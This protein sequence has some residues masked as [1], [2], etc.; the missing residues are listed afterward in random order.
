M[1]KEII[2]SIN[3]PL[4]K[5]PFSQAIK[6]NNFVFLSGQA[7]LDPVSGDLKE[8]NDISRQTEIIIKNIKSI[9]KEAN[10]TLDNIVKVNAFIKNSKDFKEFNKAYMK[11]FKKNQPA[12]RTIVISNFDEEGI[13]IE[14]D[15]IAAIP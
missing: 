9:L 15:V 5:G 4:P 2:L 6:A 13:C 14:M 3:A 12:R 11:Y 8:P 10:C 7:A 1:N